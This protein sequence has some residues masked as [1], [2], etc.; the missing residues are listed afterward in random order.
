MY[1]LTDLYYQYTGT[2]P[3]SCQKIAGGGSNRQYYRL[4]G[5]GG[6]S[7]IGAIGTSVEEN[8][9]FV[10]LANH[11]ADCGL[12]VPH[13]VA[14]SPDGLSYLQTDLGERTLYDAVRTGREGGQGYSDEHIAL[15]RQTI[16]LLPKMQ[17][18]GAVGLDFSKCY[19]QESMNARNVMFD[20]NYFKYCF[21]KT[22]GL[23]FNEIRLEECFA[24]MARTLGETT[25]S[26]YFMYRDF[27]ARNVM[28]D[29]DDAPYFI[30]FQG[31]RRGPLQYDLVSF[32]WQASSHFDKPLRKY[33]IDEYIVALKQ[34]TDIDEVS[35]RNSIPG[36]VLFRTLQV[37]GAY[38]FRG[39]FEQKKYFLDSIP[40]AIDNL[41]DILGDVNSCPYP[42]LREV[43]TAMVNLPEF[44]TKP[45]SETSSATVPCHA[46]GREVLKVRVFSFSYKK[47]I[48][49]DSSGNGG[50]YVF[51]CRGTHNPGRYEPYKK[52]TGLDRP[53]IDFLETDGE[54]TRFME[55]VY[56]LAD[57]HVAR[58][59]ERGF[60]S[61]MFCFGCTG[62]QHRSVYCAQH[63]A[64]YI[65]T[66]YGIEVQIT[67]REQG[68]EHVLPMRRKAMIFAAG[69]GTR[70][71]PLTDTMPKALVPVAGKPL[72]E[73]VMDKLICAG[74][75]DIVIN[76]HHFADMIEDWGQSALIQS[77]SD[78][79]IR[80]SFSDERN[81]LLETGGGIA[82][83]AA[84]LTDN[85]PEQ[86][87]LV[88][89]VDILSNVNLA[90][91]WEYASDADAVLLVSARTTSRYLIFDDDMRLVGWTNISTGEIRSPYESVHKTLASR[92]K[93]V[94][95]IDK[96]HLRAFAGIHQIKTGLLQRMASMPCKFSIVDFY[97][98][99][100]TQADIRGYV[101]NDLRLMD[102]GKTDSLSRAE[103]F[104]MLCQPYS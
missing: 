32:L 44:C 71:K 80:I 43:L 102:V 95:D 93:D 38:G 37:L 29:A 11:F 52:L 54:I 13:V 45:S 23:D 91:F 48:P 86:R 34:Y 19:P 81:E 12:P 66:R 92:A 64:E 33:L 75:N 65:N 53:V 40:A 72:I 103:Q 70:L 76:V 83:A 61:L 67:H 98:N 85:N 36:W 31:G 26:D 35:F 55:H 1:S 24:E 94:L 8:N 84:L 39:K 62:G 30:D 17:I 22:T 27:Q 74:F 101:Q 7:M 2:R 100:C 21:L 73:H 68:I 47:G 10:Y 50:G 79:K 59:M 18:C 77:Y 69:L 51:D 41:R 46:Y 56:K 58:Y 97:I 104:I 3:S 78:K 82:H 87:F 63:L 88:H 99:I 89:N 49:N 60:T 14:V 90:A 25:S 6:A 42:Y 96:Y 20:L 57:T 28:L 16:R 4:T 15:L 9:A 5:E